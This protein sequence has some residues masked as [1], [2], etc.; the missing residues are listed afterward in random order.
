MQHTYTCARS[1]CS[2]WA[3]RTCSMCAQCTSNTCAHSTCNACA[4]VHAAHA[5]CVLTAHAACVHIAHATHVHIAHAT[6][7][8]MCTQHMPQVRLL[9]MQ[10]VCPPRMQSA[11][12]VPR[13][14]VA[15]RQL[16]RARRGGEGYEH[17]ACSLRRRRRRWPTAPSRGRASRSTPANS[18]QLQP[19]TSILTAA[20]RARG[21]EQNN[22]NSINKTNRPG[23]ER[24]GEPRHAA[25][26]RRS[27]SAHSGRWV[28]ARLAH[29]AS[30]WRFL[31]RRDRDLVP[32]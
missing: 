28:V 12:H 3:Y 27:A 31:L 13:G 5:A 25:P 8:H 18:T 26:C 11:K 4:H 9:H 7:V 21:P 15:R 19:R 32:V 30:S 24:V 22:P 1:T 20:S 17:G 23:P 10:H 16:L 14:V 2:M 29:R 6:H